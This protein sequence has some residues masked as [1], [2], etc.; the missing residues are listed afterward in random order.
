[1][2]ALRTENFES[3]EHLGERAWERASEADTTG[4][5]DVRVVLSGES[6]A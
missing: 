2:Q 1:V 6:A 5:G 4:G 3:W